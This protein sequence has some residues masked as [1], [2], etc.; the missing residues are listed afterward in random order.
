MNGQL[1]AVLR[2]EAVMILFCVVFAQSMPAASYDL[3]IN[4]GR[5]L[6]PQSGLDGTRSIGVRDGKIA[7]I[8]RTPLS[9][10]NVID[11]DGQIVGPGFIDYHAHGGTLL[12]GRLQAF[13]G[14]T[15][16]IEA[17]VGQLPVAMAYA[18]AKGE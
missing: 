5:V 17:E 8:S 10:K 1:V 2:S 9:G 3:V 6:D 4:N 14:V 7:K 11:A 15:T 18:R 12:S 13:D 16:A